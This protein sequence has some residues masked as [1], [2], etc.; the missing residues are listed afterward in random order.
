MTFGGSSALGSY[1]PELE[2]WIGATCIGESIGL[3]YGEATARLGATAAG[4]STG[5]GTAAGAATGGAASIGGL[6]GGGILGFLAAASMG[7]GLL[8]TGTDP[9][10]CE[11]DSS[12]VLAAG[13]AAPAFCVGSV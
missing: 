11:L 9:L 13:T 7:I 2:L 4:C 10:G 3:T 6:I 8:A 12:P 1:G 5:G